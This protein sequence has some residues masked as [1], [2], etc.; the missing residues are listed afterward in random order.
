MS[1]QFLHFTSL[2]PNEY[3]RAMVMTPLSKA[4]R[5]CSADTLELELSLI[6]EV[7]DTNVYLKRFIREHIEVRTKNDLTIES[8]F[9]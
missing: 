6:A 4:S 2:S 8:E 9:H 5:I 7:L 1:E 3:K